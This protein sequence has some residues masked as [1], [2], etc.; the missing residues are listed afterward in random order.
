MQEVAEGTDDGLR[1]VARQRVEE[2]GEFGAGGGVAV[3]GEAHGGLADALDD[4]EDCIPFLFAHGIAENPAEKPDVGVQR[5]VL[6][7]VGHGLRH[8]CL[9]TRRTEASDSLATCSATEP[10][11]SRARPRWP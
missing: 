1:R 9:R 2:G 11:R 8:Q 10:R 6:V 7:A 4:R 3:A 5:L